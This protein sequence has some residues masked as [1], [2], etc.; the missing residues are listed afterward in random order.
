[1]SLQKQLDA[2]GSWSLTLKDSTPRSTVTDLLR[3]ADSGFALLII[4]P[5]HVNPALFTRAQLLAM[6]VFTGVFRKQE[7]PRRLL[8]LSGAHA[9]AWAGDENGVGPT[10]PK[11]IMKNCEP[12]S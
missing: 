6:S 8:Q 4:T 12:R 1:M 7:G 2:V 11:A 3:M 10:V 9:T 5:T